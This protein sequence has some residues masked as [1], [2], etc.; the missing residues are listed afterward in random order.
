[1][2]G[3]QTMRGFFFGKDHF[4]VTV[5]KNVDYAFIASLIVILVEIEKA[6]FIT[7]MTTQMII[8]F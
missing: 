4:S 2:C 8:G 1:M 6:G 5:D 7:K 3:K